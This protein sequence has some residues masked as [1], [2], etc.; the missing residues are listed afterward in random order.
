MLFTLTPAAWPEGYGEALLPLAAAKTWLRIDGD[1]EDDLVKALRDA[2]ID[3]VEQYTN[4]RLAP[5]ADL[6]ARFA[7]FGPRMRVGIGPAA[8]L[9]VSTINYTDASGA[10]AAIGDGM[11]RVD[12]RG[13]LVPAFGTAWPLCASDV[14]VTFTAGYSAGTCPS[15]LIHAAKLFLGHLYANRE[16]VL[17]GAVSAELPLGFTSLCDRYRMPV[18]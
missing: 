4:L 3:A 18:L 15:G 13:D 9:R 1:D 16:A 10:P 11:W 2:A 7:T 12:P 17:V 14:I 6:V 8:S 5:V